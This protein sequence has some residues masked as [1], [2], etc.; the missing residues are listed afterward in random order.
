MTSPGQPGADLAL[1]A[2][3]MAQREA[4]QQLRA[5][6]AVQLLG[7]LLVGHVAEPKDPDLD[8]EVVRCELTEKAV[9]WGDE[10]LAV[11]LRKPFNPSDPRRPY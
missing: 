9:E 6:V 8:E 4:L 7:F 3:G 10:L 5:Q 1:A 2:L 11:V